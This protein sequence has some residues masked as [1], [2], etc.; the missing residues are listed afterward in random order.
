MELPEVVVLAAEVPID[1]LPVDATVPVDPPLDAVVPAGGVAQWLLVGSHSSK[2]QSVS[3]EQLK[4][5]WR[6]HVFAKVL[7]ANP[8]HAQSVFV[9]HCKD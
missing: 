4:P 2:Q 6:Q 3:S 5:G 1:P 7:H 8:A 9:A